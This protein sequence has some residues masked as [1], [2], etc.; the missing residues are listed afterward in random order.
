MVTEPVQGQEYWIWDKKQDRP[1]CVRFRDQDG[2]LF[3]F[4]PSDPIKDGPEIRNETIAGG[5][6]DNEL[7]CV[8]RQCYVVDEEHKARS[9]H[10]RQLIVELIPSK[11]DKCFKCGRT[12]VVEMDSMVD[13][14]LLFEAYG[15]YGSTIF[16]PFPPGKECLRIFVCDEC[17]KTYNLLATKIGGRKN[18]E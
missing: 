17:V 12:L 9:L 14:G 13:D 11:N 3:C 7:D 4:D 18:H 5:I 2:D 6:F 10:L 1:I 8:Y 16:D 15:N